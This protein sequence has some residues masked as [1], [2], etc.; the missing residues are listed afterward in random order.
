MGISITFLTCAL[1][2]GQMGE[3]GDWQLSPQLAPGLELVYHGTYVEE[4]L[5]PNVQFQRHYQMQT[6]VL[7]LDSVKGANELAI[8]TSLSPTD[9]HG[10]AKKSAAALR[11]E[12]GTVDFQGNLLDSDKQALLIP[13]MG[14]PAL[15]TGF[16]VPTPVGKL[17]RNAT[18]EVNE[19]GRAPRVWQMA[20]QET[21]NGIGCLKVIGRQQ[22][23]DWDHPRADKVGW[24]RQDTVWLSPQ[25]LVA[26]K[27][28][29]VI[30]RRDPARQQ[31][32]QRTT[33]RYELE[34]RL[35]YPGRLFEDRRADVLR[36]RQLQVDVRALLRSPSLSHAALDA[37]LKKI[38]SAFEDQAPTPYRKAVAPLV[39]SLEAAKRG[40]TSVAVSNDEPRPFVQAVSP[41]QRAPD[42]VVSSLTDR[43]SSR[44][45]RDLGK[46]VLVVFYNPATSTG[47][48]VILFAKQLSEEQKAGLTVYAMAVSPDAEQARKQ[49]EELKLPFPVLDGHGMR[50][51]FGAES[52]PRLVVLDAQGIVRSAQTGWGYET[53]RDIAEAL[54]RCRQK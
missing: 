3:R 27:V 10:D 8:L 14:P 26:Q 24:R 25:L 12:L 17:S 20:G 31:P 38:A 42:F 36:I 32:T 40:E 21:C 45:Y 47:R 22:S 2:L 43:E 49:H 54:E 29:R 16:V 35:R 44:L 11:M 18:W 13:I 46:P 30:E 37:Q 51:T 50:R 33:T 1:A 41:G 6:Y 52:T 28:E 48:E 19:V 39:A 23:D 53:P 15:E 34:S 7:V 9:V 4:S 5:I